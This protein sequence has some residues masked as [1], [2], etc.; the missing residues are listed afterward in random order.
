MQGNDINNVG[1]ITLYEGGGSLLEIIK[2][3]SE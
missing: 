3:L 2:T 1:D